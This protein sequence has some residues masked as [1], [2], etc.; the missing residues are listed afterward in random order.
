MGDLRLG[1]RALRKA[2]AIADGAVFDSDAVAKMW[3]SAEE[4]VDDACRTDPDSSLLLSDGRCEQLL[5]GAE[6][7]TE[8]GQRPS[9]SVISIDSG[10]A[11]L[12]KQATAR[13]MD[14]QRRRRAA[15]G[16]KKF[17]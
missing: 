5:A 9:S 11:L 6:S 15:G 16:L 12:G 1:A 7:G 4:Q 14:S 17:A 13:F 10:R 8:G 3:T 2:K